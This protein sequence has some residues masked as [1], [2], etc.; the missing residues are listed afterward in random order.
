MNQ[1][2]SVYNE[3]GKLK[4]VVVCAPSGAELVEPINEVQ[5]FFMQ[6]DPPVIA[7]MKPQFETWLRILEQEQVELAALPS[8]L[9]LPEQVF[10]RDIA[11]AIGEQIFL[12]NMVKPVRRDEV[13]IIRD[14]FDANGYCYANIPRGS[15]EG[16]DV[17]IDYPM[18]YI[19][20]GERTEPEAVAELRKL[21]STEWQV[22]PVRLAPKVLHLDCVV[23]I[24]E[25]DLIMWCP[26]LIHEADRS[27][28][29][30]EFPRR[31]V[32]TTEQVLHMG[33]NVLKITSRLVTIES[34]QIKL[35]SQ[36]ANL[37]Y[38]VRS[39]DWS[40]IKKFGGLFRCATA[41]LVRI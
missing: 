23:S 3:Y 38:D 19:G 9:T 37:G 13:P 26:E 22:V 4:K 41:P 14:W 15:I 32:I 36:L 31:I 17:L 39:V 27:I 20:L 21:L 12:A 34:R 24:L 10:T 25:D 6:H 30:A 33:A 18:V 29:E 8:L 1:K 16:G 2:S 35:R 7:L 40:E 28:F 5:R 11:F